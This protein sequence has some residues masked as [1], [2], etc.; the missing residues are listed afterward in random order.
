MQRRPIRDSAQ[1]AA[2]PP[3]T[4][5]ST[6]NPEAGDYA[7]TS[8]PAEWA[9]AQAAARRSWEAFP[10][11]ATRY[12]ERGW[13]FTLSDT[14][15]IAALCALPPT[16]VRAQLA[17]LQGL[18]IPRG[19]PSWLL[20]WHLVALHEELV[21]GTPDALDRY[22]ALAAG[23]SM[24]R[25]ERVRALPDERLHAL[26]GAFDASVSELPA[27]VPKIGAILVAAVVDEAN[28]HAGALAAVSTWA[29]DPARFPRAW[30]EAVDECVRAARAEVRPRK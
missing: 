6:V 29:K 12:G 2:P 5:A 14:G 22:A 8:D 23:A 9:A 25:A 15:W 13:R 7:I 26:G 17:W 1:P 4:P 18:L 27:A 24:L 3:R 19:M 16:A 10:Y 21:A 11:Y 30:R 20:E 28:G